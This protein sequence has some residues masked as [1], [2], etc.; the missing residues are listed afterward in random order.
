[1]KEIDKNSIGG[2][3]L[4]ASAVIAVLLLMLLSLSLSTV[5]SGQTGTQTSEQYSYPFSVLNSTLVE[6]SNGN[7][8]QVKIGMDD[9]QDI[10]L[11]RFYLNFSSPFYGAGNVSSELITKTSVTTGKYFSLSYP[12]N[13]S[14][15]ASK[16]AYAFTLYI[17]YWIPFPYGNVGK[18][19]HQMFNLTM[20]FLGTTRI[21]IVSSNSAMTAGE[22][23][24]LNLSVHNNGTGDITDLKTS[25]SSQSQLTFL[26]SFPTLDNL[27]SGSSYKFSES[28]FVS[29]TSSGVITL[30]FTLTYVNPY[31]AK[32]TSY[33]DISM[34]VRPLVVSIN[35]TP[36]TTTLT[37]GATNEVVFNL[38][39]NGNGDL[40][41]VETQITSQSQLSFLKQLPI[42]GS[43]QEGHS[44]VWTEPIYVSKSVS[45]AV[46]IEFSETYTTPSG[47]QS[48]EQLYAGFHTQQSGSE[49]VT[50]QVK[51]LSTYVTLGINSS[52]DLEVTNIGNSTMYSPAIEVSAP[53]G[54]TITGNTTF[55]YPNEALPTGDSITVPFFISSSPSTT[56]GAYS[57]TI[58]IDYYNST[59]TE[60]SKTF[61]AGFLA[62]AKVS[63]VVQGFS[64]NASGNSVTISGTLLD[65]GAGSAY[66]LTLEGAFSQHGTSTSGKT[67]LGEIDS[68]TPTPFSLTFNLPAGTS[69]GTS[70]VSIQV[71]YQ[72][73]YGETVNSTLL[74]TSIAFN[75]SASHNGQNNTNVTH[76]NSL[77]LF[78]ILFTVVIVIIVLVIGLVLVQRRRNRRRKER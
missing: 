6:N 43:L 30:N 42:I 66:Y 16:G 4:R 45:G 19:D 3:K 52:A 8:Y 60:I 22:T 31:G 61:S 64:E 56:Q 24:A 77:R 58:K 20:E 26:S 67:Y 12:I 47:T 15:N 10:S 53:T 41:N 33:S 17:Q 59:G 71:N 74:S 37:S 70:T 68:N 13:V 75:S 23:N 78:G 46:T 38:T 29:S 32:T 72:N 1:M 57:A 65:E 2:S 54:F 14:E 21:E 49:N 25:S 73:Y 50:M 28:A 34:G 11:A 63:L 40:S 18:A 76:F 35:V 7:T 69:N 9:A 36:S 48:S 55:Y 44:F 39:N 51:L 27:G 5:T 62:L